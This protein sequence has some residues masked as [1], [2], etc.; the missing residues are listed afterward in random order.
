[1]AAPARPPVLPTA[2]GQA[3]APSFTLPKGS[4]PGDG[5]VAL[6]RLGGASSGSSKPFASRTGRGAGA[7]WE[8]PTAWTEHGADGRT[9]SARIS[10]SHNLLPCSL[11][12]L[13]F[14]SHGAGLRLE[15]ASREPGRVSERQVFCSEHHQGQYTRPQEDFSLKTDTRFVLL[16]AFFRRVYEQLIVFPFSR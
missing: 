4:S 16:C 5:D 3:P 13:T 6:A 10:V 8:P 12:R 14:S 11:P 9:N 7:L 2:A 1:M 15:K